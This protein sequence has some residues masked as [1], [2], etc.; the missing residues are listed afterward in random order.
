MAME[1]IREFVWRKIVVVA[2]MTVVV[3]LTACSMGNDKN[4]GSYTVTYD[5]NGNTGGE[6]PVDSTNYQEDGI[7]RRTG[8]AQPILGGRPL[9]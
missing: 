1:V 9:S 2:L 8:T 3:L 7:L 4:E 6:V 5:G